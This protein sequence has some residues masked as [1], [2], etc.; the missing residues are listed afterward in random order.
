MVYDATYRE[1]EAG[2]AGSGLPCARVASLLDDLGFDVK[3]C[4]APGHKVFTHDHLEHFTSSGYNC[5]GGTG[6]V[7]RNYVG[8]IM[9]ILRTH[10]VD[11]R[12]H[13]GE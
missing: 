4:A 5:K 13:L 1:F 6:V 10:E 11:L 12:K 2:K 8:K 9:R 3:D 7:D